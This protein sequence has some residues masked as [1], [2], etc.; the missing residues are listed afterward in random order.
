MIQTRT[1]LPAEESCEMLSRR[2]NISALL[3]HVEWSEKLES[4][5]TDATRFVLEGFDTVK[6]SSASGSQSWCS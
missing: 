4:D 3:G 1:G 5:E 6:S 2:Y